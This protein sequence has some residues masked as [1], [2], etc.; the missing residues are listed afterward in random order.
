MTKYF[1]SWSNLEEMVQ[2]F[3]EHEYRH[4]RYDANCKLITIYEDLDGI[5]P[6]DDE[7]LF[8]SYGGASYEG[9][10]VVLFKKDG[11]LY[12]AG[13]SHC[14]C[15]GLEGQWEPKET[16]WAAQA[17]RLSLVEADDGYHNFLQDHEK[18]AQI[19]WVTLVKSN[20][21]NQS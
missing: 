12:E 17:L 1:G 14:S 11:K 7:V 6:I 18:E 16:A 15:Y 10:A 20:L 21:V 3:K 9:H 5:V 13:G 19:A 4:D 2:S 8:A